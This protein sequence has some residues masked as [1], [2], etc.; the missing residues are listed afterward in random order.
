MDS[1]NGLS[2]RDA[3]AKSTRSACKEDIRFDASDLDVYS[4]YGECLSI[5]VIII[6]ERLSLVLRIACCCRCMHR[7]E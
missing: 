5:G 1:S 6:N 4:A 2:G 7:I 3:Y